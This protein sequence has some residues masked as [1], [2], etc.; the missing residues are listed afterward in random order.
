[1]HVHPVIGG[2]LAVTAQLSQAFLSIRF[3]L[4]H[5]SYSMR[6]KECMVGHWLQP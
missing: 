5:E 4:Q 1:M 2:G 3:D 6:S